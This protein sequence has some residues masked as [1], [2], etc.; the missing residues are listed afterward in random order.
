MGIAKRTVAAAQAAI[1]RDRTNGTPQNTQEALADRHV[2]THTP[3][4]PYPNET[5]ETDDDNGTETAS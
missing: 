1:E 3:E 4:S 5:D 2:R